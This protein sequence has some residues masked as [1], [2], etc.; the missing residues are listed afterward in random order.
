[1]TSKRIVDNTG[2]EYYDGAI[3]NISRIKEAEEKLKQHNEEL[4]K[5]NQELDRFVYSASHDLRAPLLSIEGLIGI[6]KLEKDK[7]QVDYCLSLMEKSVKKLDSFIKDII[8]YSRNKRLILSKDKIN[9]EQIITT[10]FE[11]LKYL[12]KSQYIKPVLK[13]E[14]IDN[15]YTDERRLKV[16]LYNLVANAINYSNPLQSEPVIS[17]CVTLIEEKVQVQISDNGQGIPEQHLDRIFEMFYRASEQEDGSGLGTV[18]C[19]RNTYKIER[20]YKGGIKSW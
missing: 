2:K 7:G 3:R 6:T 9:F 5:V 16:I 20:K 17:I 15:F 11:D 4:K 10:I 8:S 1:M 18:Y 19:Q 13:I 12:K 14:D